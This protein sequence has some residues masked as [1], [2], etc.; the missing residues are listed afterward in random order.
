MK[1]QILLSCILAACATGASA[2]PSSYMPIGPNIGYGD[3]S[4]S[5][6]IYSPLANPSY[7]AINQSDTNGYRVGLG[8]GFQ[9]GVESH[10]LQGYADYFK[11]NI[12]SILDKTYT[13]PTNANNAKNQLQT[14]LNTYFSKYNQGN[15]SV[16]GGVTIPLLIKSGSFS[17]GLSLDISR[18]A[19]TKVNVVD[20]T[21]TDI[22]VTATSNGSDYNL[23]VNNGAAA[24]NLSYKELTEVALGY[25]TN[26]IS[27][28]NATLSLGVTARY[29]SLLSNT[30]MV[31]FSQIVRENRGSRNKDTGD[32]LSNLNT[33]S[34]ETAITAD[35]G[36]NWIHKN[37]SIGLVG[38]N[39][40]SPKFKTHNLSNASASTAFANYIESDFT[41]KPQYRVTG[42]INTE[43]RHWTIAGSYDLA[44]A[45]DLNN[46]DTQWWSASASFA[47][48]SA[49]YLPDVRLGLRGNMAGNKYTYTDVGLTFGILNLDVATTTTDFSGVIDKQKDAGLIA[50]AGIE[51][52]F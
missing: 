38:M 28:N 30:K 7:N 22:N 17:G 37:Y 6:T 20:N 13:N 18:Q 52:D 47:T 51:F 2:A 3:A 29:L 44:K 42:Q 26:I 8:A 34:S 31:D 41:L 46:Q 39:L 9:I 16:T 10:G 25:G 36:L 24:W 5:N 27:N 49:W 43:S 4:N 12:Q 45:N 32:Y 19:A 48:N 50:S 1:Q 33:G 14:N 23:S 21:N 11:N 35:V 15:I 40:T